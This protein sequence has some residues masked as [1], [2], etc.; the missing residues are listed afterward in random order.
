MSMLKTK[1]GLGIALMIALFVF[2]AAVTYHEWSWILGGGL[3]RRLRMSRA[4]LAK[5]AIALSRRVI[6]EMPATSAGPQ[7][8]P[9]AT[10][11]PNGLAISPAARLRT[12]ADAI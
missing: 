4:R 8:S 9:F 1:T 5:R 6:A 2:S 10:G 3:K 11:F 12:E 7:P